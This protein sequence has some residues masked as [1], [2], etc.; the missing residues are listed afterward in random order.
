MPSPRRRTRRKQ[1]E[2]TEP[3]Y[4]ELVLGPAPRDGK[5]S[6]FES[7]AAREA[8]WRDHGADL[9]AGW[10]GGDRTTTPLFGERKYE[11]ATA[12]ERMGNG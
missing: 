1:R 11:G 2:L 7:E 5:Q 9:V 10:R 8:A 4:W 6:A 3:E 12:P